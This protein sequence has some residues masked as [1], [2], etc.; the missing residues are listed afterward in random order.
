MNVL[1]I[2]GAV[3]SVALMISGAVVSAAF[4]VYLSATVIRITIELWKGEP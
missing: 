1:M 3:V 4:S 2:S